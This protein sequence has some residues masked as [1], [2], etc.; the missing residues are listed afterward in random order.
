RDVVVDAVG[1][2]I[3][4]ELDLDLFGA[5][6][7]VVAGVASGERGC[8][9]ISLAGL[10]ALAVDSGDDGLGISD[11]KL[12]RTTGTRASYARRG[13]FTVL[14]DDRLTAGLSGGNGIKHTE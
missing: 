2:C 10:K 12:R 7:A 13:C 1:G 5:N 3:G 11:R 6:E 14:A 4:G 8:D 9:D